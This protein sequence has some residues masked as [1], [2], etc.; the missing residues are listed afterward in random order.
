MYFRKGNRVSITA[1][2][3]I[4][5]SRGESYPSFKGNV[6]QEGFD[7]NYAYDVKDEKTGKVWTVYGY[8]I[9]RL[10]KR[11]NPCSNSTKFSFAKTVPLAAQLLKREG[12]VYVP[13]DIAHQVINKLKLD[14]K[15]WDLYWEVMD[16]GSILLMV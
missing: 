11:K 7:D 15:K 12:G 4:P 13:F 10:L 14:K 16:D 8:S 6:L 5:E 3:V 9:S 1:L 2:R